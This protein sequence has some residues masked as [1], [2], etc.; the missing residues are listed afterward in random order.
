MECFINI[1]NT[2]MHLVFIPLNMAVEKEIIKSLHCLV[3]LAPHMSHLGCY[4][5]IYVKTS[6]LKTKIVLLTL[7]P[8]SF[9]EEVKYVRLLTYDARW[10]TADSWRRTKTNCN[11]PKWLSWPKNLMTKW[12]TVLH[13]LNLSLI[14]IT[15]LLQDCSAK[16]HPS[17]IDMQA[18]SV[19]HKLII[20]LLIKL[21]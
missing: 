13:F 12:Q 16:K 11:W 8:C 1:T 5:H 20:I 9:E 14:H 4:G 17:P 18:G 19:I 15:Y 3:N 10:M 2:S 7:S 6:C 21:L